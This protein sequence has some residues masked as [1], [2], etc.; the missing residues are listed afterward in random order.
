MD[1]T[2]IQECVEIKMYCQRTGHNLAGNIIRLGSI[3]IKFKLY[4]APFLIAPS[5]TLQ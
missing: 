1:K 2:V 5:R 4:M 3:I